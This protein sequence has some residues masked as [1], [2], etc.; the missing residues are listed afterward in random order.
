MIDLIKSLYRACRG[1]S[2][3]VQSMSK[4]AYVK[5]PMLTS[6]NVISKRSART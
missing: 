4:K 6:L 3:S 1:A 5:K 2:Y